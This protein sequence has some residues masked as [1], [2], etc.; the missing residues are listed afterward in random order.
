MYVIC[1]CVLTTNHYVCEH[2]HLLAFSQVCAFAFQVSDED[3]Q[4]KFTSNPQGANQ[5]PQLI[6]PD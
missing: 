2:F 6:I 4:M 3:G 5:V 1:L